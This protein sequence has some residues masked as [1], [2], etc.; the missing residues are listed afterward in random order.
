MIRV[1]RGNPAPAGRP[2]PFPR[3]AAAA[4]VLALIAW[5][6][7]RPAAAG[8][9]ISILVS[10][11]RDTSFTVSWLTAAAETGQVQLEGDRRY[12]DVRGA[13]FR[14]TTHYVVVSGLAASTTF[15]FEIA[16]GGD[17]SNQNGTPW[18][19]TT[20]AGL[21][22]PVPDLIVGR[23]RHADGTD[24]TDAIVVFTVQRGPSISAPLS[25]LLTP[26][27]AGF[28]HI[29]LS[30]L[31]T[32]ENPGRYFEYAREGDLLTIQ[33]ADGRAVGLLK[34]DTGDPRL[35]SAA[36]QGALAVQLGGQNETPTLI[37]RLPTPTA[38][39]APVPAESRGAWVGF[40]AAA[41]IGAGVLLVAIYYV[42]R[43]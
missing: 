35:R 42:W 19:V 7:V 32:V 24:A 39:P 18:T 29:Q 28:F 16:S 11:V 27:D 30:E 9:L 21:P 36:P 40:G 1:T 43:R 38:N 5:A 13:S 26:A 41:I 2:S 23:V 22:P 37:V 6:G 12:D 3:A 31:R 25:M 17:R 15:R 8:T 33:A 14:G 10:N 4:L 34:V 20:G